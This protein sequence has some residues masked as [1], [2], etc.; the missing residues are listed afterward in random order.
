MTHLIP[1]NLVPALMLA[2]NATLI[3]HNSKTD[4]RRQYRIVENKDCTKHHVSWIKAPGTESEQSV[5]I[6]T[7][8]SGQFWSNRS[9]NLDESIKFTTIFCAVQ[10]NKLW[11]EMEVMH[12]GRCCA[13]GRELTDPESIALGIGPHCGGRQ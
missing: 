5:Y 3:F 8:S 9:D 4:K 2:G 1:H 6:G 12:V 10:A 13:C 11:P 7:I